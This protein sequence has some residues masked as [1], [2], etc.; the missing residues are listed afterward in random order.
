M[1]FTSQSRKPSGHLKLD[2][3]L[4]PCSSL[5]CLV[6][7]SSA[8]SVCF[9]LSEAGQ[10]C[11]VNCPKS[12][13]CMQYWGSTM[14]LLDAFY[15]LCDGRF[16]MQVIQ[17]IVTE[18]SRRSFHWLSTA[19]SHDFLCQELSHLLLYVTHMFQSGVYLCYVFVTFLNCNLQ[20]CVF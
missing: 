6:W 13:Y 9:I 11:T 3:S 17:L 5:F 2:A 20:K 4:I 8:T 16:L 14:W 15:C 1:P 7:S 19:E 10:L 18:L 12:V